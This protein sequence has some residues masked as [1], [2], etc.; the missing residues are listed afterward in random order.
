M[1]V[2]TPIN[3]TIIVQKFGGTSMGT[4]ERILNVARRAIATQ[5][6][7]NQV[8]IVVSAMGDSTDDLIALA[9]QIA[10]TPSPREYDAL[11]STGENVSASLLAMAIQALGSK[12]ISLT[13]TQ[14]GIKTENLHN[15]AK[16]IDIDTTRI[17]Q[18][19]ASGHIVIVTGFQ[20]YNE[21]LDVTTIGRG[22]SDTSAVVL[23]AALSAPVC[24][25]FTDVEGVYTTDPRIVK[26]ASKLSEISYD[27]MLELASLGAKVLHPRS[28]ECAKQNGIVLHV[29]S[30][31]SDA[32]GTLV[33]ED[34]EMEVQRSV[35]GVATSA[36][37]A[38]ISVEQIPDQPGYAG[39]LF[40]ELANASINVD[41]IIQS[42]QDNGTNTISFTV[43]E[44]DLAEA[45]Q[46][47]EQAATYMGAKSVKIVT[48][49]A[50]V[51]IV[52]V[53]MISKPGIAARMFRVLGQ[54]GINLS[55][56]STSE[57]KISCAISRTDS[58]R[59]V[60]LLHHEFGL[61]TL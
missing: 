24:E 56:I 16:I 23:A 5:Q 25:I 44:D 28:V 15:K 22:G 12:S 10:P 57:I 46:I 45:K 14:S 58:T 49:I 59:A 2:N 32:L 36:D 40:T 47:S 6:Q 35:T 11:I 38:I 48:E 3:D 43:Q 20:G 21:S 18:E 7:Y 42:A 29:R 30:S 37:E 31:F 1:S 50:K 13:G 17:M 52:G 60:Q 53:G 39:Q 26:D 34:N 61:A 51:S 8:V 33:K 54:N 9:K 41:M 19:L 27:E 55:L 4:P